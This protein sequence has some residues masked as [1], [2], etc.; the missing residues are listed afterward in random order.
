MLI[1]YSRLICCFP[2]NF[3]FTHIS[4]TFSITLVTQGS[5]FEHSSCFISSNWIGLIF[6]SF[7]KT[8]FIWASS[9][10]N[11]FLEET[12]L[13][14]L[15]IAVLSPCY[16]SGRW[17]KSWPTRSLFYWSHL[18]TSSCYFTHQQSIKSRPNCFGR[19][20]L[21]QTSLCLL[22]AL[23]ILK[24]Q[25][26]RAGKAKQVK[27]QLFIIFFHLLLHVEIVDH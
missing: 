13:C 12:W 14:L 10:T 5:Y 3:N 7:S 4:V 18:L 22:K 25:G 27:K 23:G 19:S 6:F 24:Y 21:D 2:K 16:L 26:C 9:M 11:F 15:L 1:E 20:H 17:K 8:T